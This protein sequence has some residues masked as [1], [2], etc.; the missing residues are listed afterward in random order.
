MLPITID[1]N[2]SQISVKELLSLVLEGKEI[3]LTEG[4]IPQACLVTMSKEQPPLSTSRTP[5]LHSGAIWTSDDF[6]QPLPD[7]F[8]TGSV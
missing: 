7:E 2:Q 3:V 8:W 4:S 5:G 6:D 1:V